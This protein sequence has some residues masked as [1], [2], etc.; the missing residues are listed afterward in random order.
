MIYLDTSVLIPLFVREAGTE[1]VL[2]WLQSESG[3]RLLASDWAV[4]EFAS[5][6]TAKVRAQHIDS[7]LAKRAFARFLAFANRHCTLLTLDRVVF[8]EATNLARDAKNG[9]RAG[10]ALHVALALISKA[11]Q[12]ACLDKAVCDS[13]ARVGFKV[14]P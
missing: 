2:A 9:L 10:D 8:H 11:R 13:A 6:I 4:T 7:E 1:R 14:A 12:F 5:A 3:T